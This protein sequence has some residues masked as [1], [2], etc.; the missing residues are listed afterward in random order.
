[1]CMYMCAGW[2]GGLKTNF[3]ES[4]LSFDLELWCGTKVIRLLNSLLKALVQPFSTQT[5]R[6]STEKPLF[7]SHVWEGNLRALALVKDTAAW[8]FS[9]CSLHRRRVQCCAQRRQGKQCLSRCAARQGT[10]VC[11]LRASHVF[12]LDFCVVKNIGP[13]FLEPLKWFGQGPSN[14]PNVNVQVLI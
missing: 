8:Q 13:P 9:A 10:E 4:V 6:K 1:M 2:G 7:F 14:T 11:F 5:T 3:Q 12:I